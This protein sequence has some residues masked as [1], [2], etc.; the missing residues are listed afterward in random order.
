MHTFVQACRIASCV[1]IVGKNE[2]TR[3]EEK[4]E[5]REVT[6]RTFTLLMTTIVTYSHGI[7]AKG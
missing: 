5:I 7:E 6:K 1:H 2:E 4:I 3:F